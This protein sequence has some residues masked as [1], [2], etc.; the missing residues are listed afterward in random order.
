MEDF[1]YEFALGRL[2]E[3]FDSYIDL[4]NQGITDLNHLKS[5]QPSE[6]II[7]PQS[8]SQTMTFFLQLHQKYIDGPPTLM[9]SVLFSLLDTFPTSGSRVALLMN[10]KDEFIML[11]FQLYMSIYG[12]TNREMYGKLLNAPQQNVNPIYNSV[13]ILQLYQS[14]SMYNQQ[15]FRTLKL[16]QVGH[17]CV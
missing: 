15:I 2:N 12:L 11:A 9:K 17:F 10:K 6:H 5:N 16:I 14:S 4:A 13:Y 3:I 8:I 1:R 7:V